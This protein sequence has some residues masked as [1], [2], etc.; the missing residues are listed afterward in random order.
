MDT[1]AQ[2]SLVRKGLLSARSLR[3]SAMLVTLTLANGEI[4]EGGLDKAEI[5]QQLLRHEQLL[6]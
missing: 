2:V 3:H 6:R 4:T 5:S 1:G